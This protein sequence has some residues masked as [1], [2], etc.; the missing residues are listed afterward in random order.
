MGRIAVFGGFAK[1][2]TLGLE[3]MLSLICL[4]SLN[5]TSELIY[6]SLRRRVSDFVR[7]YN[8]TYPKGLCSMRDW[9]PDTIEIDDWTDLLRLLVLPTNKYSAIQK[10]ILDAIKLLRHKAIHREIIEIDA[11]WYSM[12]FPELLDDW[13]QAFGI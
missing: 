2:G 10:D 12:K 13:D 4:S 11:L 5:T 1:H 3:N 8:G 9:K 7:N 6:F